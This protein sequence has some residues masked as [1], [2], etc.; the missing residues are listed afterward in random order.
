MKHTGAISG[1]EPELAENLRERGL[2]LLVVLWIIVSAT[3][4]VLSFNAT[5]RS[6]ATFVVSEVEQAKTEAVL[7][8]GV[9]IAAS[10]LID[11]EEARRWP[12][13]GSRRMVRFAG[14]DLTISILDANGLIDLNKSDDKILLAFFRQFTGSDTKAA[15]LRD[16]I[17]S[18]REDV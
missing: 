5:V 11:S 16:Y 10:H 13:D 8:A 15:Q 1:A 9:E 12:A 14:A 2:A 17:V 3:L 7:D 4:L 18:A 6:G